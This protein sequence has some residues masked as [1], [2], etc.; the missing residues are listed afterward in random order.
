MIWKGKLV[1]AEVRMIARKVL[2]DAC[3]FVEGVTR[4]SI[5]TVPSPSPGGHAPASISG[6]LKRSIDHEMHPTKLEGRVG[7]NLDYSRRLE[8]GFSGTDS[9][10]RKYTQAPR[11]YLRPALHKSEAAIT[12][13]F[14]KAIH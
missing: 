2:E 12:L 5:G 7:T 6:D 8:L 14:R 10:G 4:A 9:L 11:P 13:M 1:E 3:V